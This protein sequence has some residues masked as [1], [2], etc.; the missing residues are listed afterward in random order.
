MQ[1]DNIHICA[2]VE[3]EKSIILSYNC[4][5]GRDFHREKITVHR[6]YM[7]PL[8]LASIAM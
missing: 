4:E 1:K 7:V 6:L 5:K 2:L 3:D 8:Q